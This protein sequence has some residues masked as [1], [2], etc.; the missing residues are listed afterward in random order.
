MVLGPEDSVNIL[1]IA[2]Q[3]SFLAIGH[4]VSGIQWCP[5][6]SE[7]IWNSTGMHQNLLN[8]PDFTLPMENREYHPPMGNWVV[9]PTPYLNAKYSLTT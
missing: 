9:P 4:P 3:L 8:H 1:A 7:T 6:H 5:D 2:Q